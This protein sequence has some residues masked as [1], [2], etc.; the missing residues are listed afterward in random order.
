MNQ[1][2]D[3]ITNQDYAKIQSDVESFLR[4]SI[5]KAGASGVVFG[6]SG[7][8]DSAVV[9]HICAKSFKEKSLA[10]LMPDSRVSPKEETEDALQIVD[11]LGLD[12]KLIDISQIHSQFANVLEPE[13]KSLGNL[14]ARIRATLLYYHANL[15][16]YLVIGSSDRS[17]QLI[18]Y[19]TKFGDGGADVLPIASLYKTQIRLLARHLGVKESIIQKKS[20][21]HLWK[22]HIAEDEIGA[23]YEEI[24]S[25][26][27]CMTDK[28]MSL[29]DIQKTT[30][31]DKDK[32]EKIHQLYKKSEHKRIMPS[33]I[34]G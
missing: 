3:E 25:I 10:L 4:E 8:I 11:K 18:G 32:I 17:E 19:F 15:K 34:Q 22:G 28:N 23:S 20:S 7:G 27:Y 16:N 6:L 29:V 26:L 30:Q 24:D 12:Y 21:P 14:R 9:A 13:E 2:L 5:S 33:R 1:I 31:I